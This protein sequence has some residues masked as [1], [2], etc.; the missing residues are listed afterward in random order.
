LALAAL[1]WAGTRGKL[2]PLWDLQG[3]LAH[4][5][6]GFFIVLLAIGAI[7]GGIWYVFQHPPGAKRHDVRQAY[8]NAIQDDPG[9]AFRLICPAT[10]R[11]WTKDQF[12]KAVRSDIRS[13]GGLAHAGFLRNDRVIYTNPDHGQSTRELPVARGGDTW[14]VCNISLRDPLGRLVQP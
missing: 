13:I 3:N 2:G 10:R 4:P 5:V 1:L 12:T 8:V 7:N 9:S 6:R 14:L 11:G